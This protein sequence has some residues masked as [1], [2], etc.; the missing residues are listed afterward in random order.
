MA[1]DAAVSTPTL[2]SIILL[3]LCGGVRLKV[4]H[5]VVGIDCWR[6]DFNALDNIVR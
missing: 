5:G 1:D 6:R 2:P 3:L 4:R